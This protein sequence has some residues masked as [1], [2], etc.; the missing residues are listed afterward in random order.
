MRLLAGVLAAVPCGPC[1]SLPAAHRY[2]SRTPV[3]NACLHTT[4]LQDAVSTLTHVAKGWAHLP[5]L[6][7]ETIEAIASFLC[8][9]DWPLA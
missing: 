3:G 8:D 1:L 7:Q 9:A 5:R 6:P 2:W 4:G